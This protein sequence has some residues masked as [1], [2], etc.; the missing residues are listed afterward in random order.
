[1]QQG[2]V[3]KSRTKPRNVLR[4]VVPT[5]DT[6]TTIPTNLE[7]CTDGDYTTATGAGSKVMDGSGTFG[8]LIFDMGSIKTVLVGA[9]VG[10]WA[11]KGTTTL[12]IS[13]SDDNITYRV[14]SNSSQ[15]HT[16]TSESIRDG[17]FP[18]IFNCRYIRLT[19]ST[20]TASTPQMKIYQVT[21]HELGV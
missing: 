2:I 13:G 10:M 18:T 15:S 5:Q 4:G 16:A 19:F 8:N 3:T 17:S 12:Y 9:R 11:D 20:S 14:I 7:R 6:F 21:A 1:M